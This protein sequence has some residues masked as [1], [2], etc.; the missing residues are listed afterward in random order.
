MCANTVSWPRLLAWW[1][2]STIRLR[3]GF[4]EALNVIPVDRIILHHPIKVKS[5]PFADGVSG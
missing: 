3:A 4:P 2:R 1:T 5:T